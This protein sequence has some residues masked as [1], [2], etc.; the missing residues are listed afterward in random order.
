MS[1]T[2]LIIK[3]LVS[4]DLGWFSI[5]RTSQKTKAKQNG[6]NIDSNIIKDIFTDYSEFKNIPIEL[7][8]WKNGKEGPVLLD[9][10]IKLQGKNWRLTG[11]IDGDEYLCVRPG[12]Y[13]LLFYSR[14][15]GK[16]RIYWELACQETTSESAV[17]H[18]QIDSIFNGNTIIKDHNTREDVIRNLRKVNL[19]LHERLINSDTV[20]TQV[21]KAFSSRHILADIMSTVVTLSSKS[22][23]EYLNI[24]ETIVERFRYMLRDQI[25]T[26]ELDH[27]STWKLA[28]G[29]KIGFIDG[30]VASIGSLG[31]EPIAIRVGEYTVKPGV[32]GDDR[33]TF[34]FKAQLVDELYDTE[35]GIFDDYS[36][37]FSKLLDMARIY[38]EAGAV[39]KSI[40]TE[41]KCDLLFLHGPLVNPAAPYADFPK[42]TKAAL[43]MFD[44]TKSELKGSINPPHGNENHFI[45]SYSY[46]LKSIFESDTPVCGIIERSTSSRIVS[47]TLLKQLSE[48]GFADEAEQIAL[49]MKE[50]R[51]SDAILFSCLL[52]EGEYIKPLRIDKNN[53]G[54]SP[55]MWK[56]VISSYPQPLTTYLKVT[57]TSYPF[58]IELNKSIED[59]SLINFIFHM[60]RLLPKY[61]FPVGLDI[62]DK[63]AKVPSWMSKQISREQSAQIL[64]SALRSG[65][66]DVVDLVRL[67]LSGTTRDWLFR[68]KPGR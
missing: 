68:P 62:V 23:I 35:D 3:K 8:Y 33:E 31:S 2:R 12:D 57:D 37:N 15:E 17:F 29:K 18:Q 66:S 5:C 36:D 25:M 42:F 61:A 20:R 65:R 58:R 63:F 40:N 60:A 22:Q 28:K 64:N 55:D 48:K 7:V 47:L 21:K 10:N 19:E 44:L 9:T 30:G 43:N 45:S 4:S 13:I 24:L 56:S 27:N 59:H 50:N 67:Y 51:I 1:N 49:S 11:K 52:K 16:S 14:E 39:Y 46:L 38:T 34:D 32:I 53:I 41:E 26:L 6:L 54:K